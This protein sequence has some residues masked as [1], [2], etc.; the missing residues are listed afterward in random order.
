[1]TLIRAIAREPEDFLVDWDRPRVLERYMA[2]LGCEV[3]TPVWASDI[4]DSVWDEAEDDNE[5]EED[6]VDDDDAAR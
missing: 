2:Y 3:A 1:M 5:E 4:P 6:D